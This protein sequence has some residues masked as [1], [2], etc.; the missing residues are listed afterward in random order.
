MGV[1][2][3][4]MEMPKTCNDCPLHE[5]FFAFGKQNIVCSPTGHALGGIDEKHLKESRNAGYCPL[6][7]IPPHGRLGDL[8][9]LKTAFPCGESI[10]TESV[11]A[12]IDHMP[13]IIQADESDMD[14]FIRIFEEDDEE[15]GMDSFIRILKD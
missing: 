1:Y 11:R 14:S 15:D 8:D 4:G 10:R 2:I 12:T 5:L 7:E 6:I 9:E 13:A 3:K